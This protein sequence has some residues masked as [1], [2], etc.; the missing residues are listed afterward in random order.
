MINPIPNVPDRS[1]FSPK[2]IKEVTIRKRG[3]KDRK[4]TVMERGD[5]F[6][7]LIYR[8]K[9]STSNGIE[10]KTASQKVLSILGISIKKRPRSRKGEEKNSLTQAM[11]YSSASS[12]LFLVKASTVDRKKAEERAY[13]THN[14]RKL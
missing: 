5:T 10:K 6:N 1:G 2:M 3:V 13:M 11:R 8:I 14:I 12:R 9:A 7:A 4:G